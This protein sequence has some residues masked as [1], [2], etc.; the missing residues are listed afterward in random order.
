[1]EPIFFECYSFLFVLFCEWFL[2]FCGVFFG[3]FVVMVSKRNLVMM[4]V[5][6]DRKYG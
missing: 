1:M 4:G 3:A 6:G 2:V 5:G